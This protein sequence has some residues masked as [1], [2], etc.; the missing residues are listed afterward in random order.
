[1]A[2]G[3]SG[4]TMRS[5]VQMQMKSSVAFYHSVARLCVELL[6]SAGVNMGAVFHLYEDR[7]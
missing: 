5:D 2:S 7:C 6:A 1:M 4:R 3:K